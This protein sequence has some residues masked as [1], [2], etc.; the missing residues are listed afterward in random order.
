MLAAKLPDLLWVLYP[1]I[2][3]PK[4]DGIRCYVHS[5]RALCRSG[6]PVPNDAARRA[7]ESILPDGIDGELTV[8]DS[9]RASSDALMRR[10]GSPLWRFR[11]FDLVS[12]R[13]YSERLEALRVAVERI[14]DPRVEFVP[15][16]SVDS[17]DDLLAYEARCLADGYEG[18]MLRDPRGPYKCGRSTLNQGWLIKLKRFS[19]SEATVIECRD[20]SIRVRDLRSGAEFSLAGSARAGAT[21][22]YW[23]QPFGSELVPRFAVLVGERHS[24]DM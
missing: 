13:P 10:G 24:A 16:E 21:V 22:T 2:V 18:V 3:T 5:G 15:W 14:D 4:I 19:D 20:R 6:K 11:A 1:V 8:G 17:R 7:L 12:D 9:F 23:Y